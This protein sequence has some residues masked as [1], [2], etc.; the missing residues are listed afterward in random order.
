LYTNRP[1]ETAASVASHAPTRIPCEYIKLGNSGVTHPHCATSKRASEGKH[2]PSLAR[3]VSVEVNETSGDRSDLNRVSC[4]ENS[5]Q[6][7]GQDRFDLSRGA[8]TFP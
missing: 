8:L 4:G 7:T 3:R 6:K 2:L 5:R 1:Q